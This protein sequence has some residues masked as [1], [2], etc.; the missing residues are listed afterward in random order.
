MFD[1]H[2]HSTLRGKSS[3]NDSREKGADTESVQRMY[4]IINHS[5][6]GIRVPM[7]IVEHY[8]IVSL[9]LLDAYFMPAGLTPSANVIS[10]SINLNPK[11]SAA[12]MIVQADVIV[13]L[14]P[15][16]VSF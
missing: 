7:H 9:N 1:Q 4:H 13:R 3:S 8:Q 14:V 10:L 5:E 12:C 11:T 15:P 16:T 2:H 6:Y